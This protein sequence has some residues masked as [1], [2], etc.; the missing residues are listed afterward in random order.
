MAVGAAGLNAVVKE[1][2]ERHIVEI[3]KELDRDCIAVY[4]P[5]VHGLES[6]VRDAVEAFGE[7]R[8]AKKRLV[9]IHDTMG[10]TVEVVERMVDTIRTF[11]EDVAFIVP[12]RAMS[13]GTIFCMSGDHILMDYF[14]RL[15]PIDP[16]IWKDDHF[17][18]AMSYIIQYERLLQKDRDKKL[19]SAEFVLLQKFNLAELHQYEQARELSIT[20]LKKWLA[21][22]KF[23]N[24]LKTE[25]TGKPVDP[26]M[27]EERART[28]AEKL[29]DAT[30]W[31]SHS[32]G[33]S[34]ETLQSD[35]IKLKIDDLAASPKVEKNVRMFHACATD[36]I[37]TKKLYPFVSS[38]IYF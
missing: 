20:L 13:A 2:L 18:P 10:G 12:D 6:K 1:S 22:Y 38:R 8:N 25:G 29:N 11:Y 28:I 35:L 7:N 17:E 23:K 26:K 3:E 5:I 30:V 9:V 37:S 27:R 19:T 4:G 21:N 33:I 15:G 31:H 36:F 16:Q 34:R 24:W 32:R 14:S